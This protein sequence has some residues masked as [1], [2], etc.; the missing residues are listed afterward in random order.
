MKIGIKLFSFRIDCYQSMFRE[1]FQQH[2]ERNTF[3]FS[4]KKDLE[5]YISNGTDLNYDS[6]SS[7]YIFSHY[8][9]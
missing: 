1:S 7:T 9:S 4:F 3:Y 5:L 2:L 8:N 6:F